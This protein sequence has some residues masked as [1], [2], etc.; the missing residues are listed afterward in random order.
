MFSLSYMFLTKTLSSF[1]VLL[2]MQILK[3]AS[4][5]SAKLKAEDRTLGV[6]EHYEVPKYICVLNLIVY[7][8][9]W[10]N[11]SLAY[12]CHGQHGTQ[13]FL[14]TKQDEIRIAQ[15]GYTLCLTVLGSYLS[16]EACTHGFESHNS[17]PNAKL[18]YNM[19]IEQIYAPYVDKC[20]TLGGDS[21]EGGGIS[22]IVLR[23]CNAGDANQKWVIKS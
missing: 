16:M 22:E 10:C 21:I 12:P 18:Q 19:E 9:M 14:L 13:E 1:K 17:G 11:S 3:S 15:G 20:V 2:Q 4:T 7:L 8:S 6:S 23:P 5:H